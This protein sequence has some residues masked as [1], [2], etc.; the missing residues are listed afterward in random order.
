MI[1]WLILF[2]LSS[3]PAAAQGL[4]PVTDPAIVLSSATLLEQ[5]ASLP[6]Y[7]VPLSSAAAAEVTEQDVQEVEEG[8]GSGEDI[9]VSSVPVEP[10]MPVNLG[11]NGRLTITRRDTGEKVTINYRT[12]DGGYDMDEVA[13]FD[14]IARCSL[15]GRETDMSI[16]LIE[17]LDKVEDHFGHRGLILLSGY[18][19]PMLNRRTPG[20]AT[21]SLHMLGWAS[22]IRVP[23]YSCTAV[24][25][26]ALKLGVGGVG[27]YPSQGFTHLD[28]GRVRYWMVRRVVHHHRRR[29]TRHARAPRAAHRSIV[30]RHRRAPASTARKRPAAAATRAPARHTGKSASK[31]TTGSRTVRKRHM[32]KRAAVK[33][34]SASTDNPS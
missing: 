34:T 24:K 11:G 10:P 21:H 8:E 28:V 29:R 20:A 3:R 26:Y 25:R 13:K 2:L 5:L 4:G 12:K 6:D 14:H 1:H 9:F 30:H 33:K 17:L 18:R 27:Y 19:T 23:G 15:T 22:D 31:R 16:K 7:S 32:S